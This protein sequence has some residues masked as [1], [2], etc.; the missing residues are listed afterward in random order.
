MELTS[1]SG[2]R[3][4]P[5]EELF[6]DY[7]ETDVRPGEVLTAVNVPVPEEGRLR[8]IPEVPAPHRRGLRHGIGGR[9]SVAQPGQ[10]LPRCP[11]RPRSAVGMTPVRARAAED[12]L[13]GQELTEDAIRAA[14]A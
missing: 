8:R 2:I 14:A 7:Y 10:H 13:R 9:C 12:L 4:C 6:I 11:N 1:P 3:I 5:I